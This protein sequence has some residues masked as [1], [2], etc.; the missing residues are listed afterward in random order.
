MTLCIEVVNVCIYGNK[1]IITGREKKKKKH[2]LFVSSLKHI[3]ERKDGKKN[4]GKEH[5]EWLSHPDSTYRNGYMVLWTDPYS[6]ATF[7]F[8]F[9]IT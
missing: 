3:M 6:W 5:A 9:Q 1:T 8:A 4:K 2:L 7:L